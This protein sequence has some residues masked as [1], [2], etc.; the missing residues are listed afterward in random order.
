MTGCAGTNPATD[1]ADGPGPNQA[2][3]PAGDQAA[4][5]AGLPAP[6]TTITSG[7]RHEG[8]GVEQPPPFQIRYGGTELHLQPVAYCTNG[9]VDGVDEDPPS[10]GSPEEIFVYVPVASFDELL[11]GQTE[12]GDE[13]TARTVDAE[14]TP[15]GAGWW[16]VRPRGL[17]GEYR[18]SIFAR[19]GGDMI[20]SIRWTTP[21]DRPLPDPSARLALI[22][23]H[24]GRPDSY[25]LELEVKD[26]PAEPTE[27]AAKITVTA[28]NG[29]SHTFAA[30]PSSELCLGEGAIYFDEPDDD[31]R[32]AAALG[33]FPF[34]TT[35]EL[36][37]DGVTYLATATYPDDEIEG[38]EPSVA[39][40]FTPPLPR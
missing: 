36:V 11:V 17:A 8:T 25:G 38:F 1:P 20:A 12:V 7:R 21:Q 5:V 30:I 28:G 37:L 19:G 22:A 6:T 9:C 32:Q 29:R 24:D 26:L 18:V 40:E 13:C 10:V 14:V 39:L 2:R 35:V 23:D 4:N 31:A 15:L 27:Y 3:D 33:D 16:E 34:T